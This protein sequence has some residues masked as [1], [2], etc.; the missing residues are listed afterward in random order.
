[1]HWHYRQELEVA[2]ATVDEAMATAHRAIVCLTRQQ[3]FLAVMGEHSGLSFEKVHYLAVAV[4][5]VKTYRRTRCERAEHDFV[6]L[7]NK[8][9]RHIVALATLETG[10]NVY[11]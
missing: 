1:M 5:A 4:V 8:P 9:A 2:V 11:F 7:I 3:F 10:S 6:V